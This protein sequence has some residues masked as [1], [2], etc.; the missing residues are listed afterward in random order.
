LLQWEMTV[1]ENVAHEYPGQLESH[2][3]ARCD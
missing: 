2:A 3:E 1:T